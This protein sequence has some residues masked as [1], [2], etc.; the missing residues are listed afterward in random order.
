MPTSPVET[1]FLRLYKGKKS[2]QGRLKSTAYRAFFGVIDADL[3]L[4]MRF[5]PKEFHFTDDLLRIAT[6]ISHSLRKKKIA[7]RR[8][9]LIELLDR[10]ADV[11]AY[12]DL[13]S[14]V[15][16]ALSS[17][18]SGHPWCI[19]MAVS[20]PAAFWLSEFLKRRL[21]PF[22]S[23]KAIGLVL[24]GCGDEIKIEVLSRGKLPRIQKL[25]QLE[26][27]CPQ[28]EPSKLPQIHKSP[29]EIES[30][31]RILFGHFEVEV[32]GVKHH[33]PAV[34]SVKKLSGDR[35]FIQY[36]HEEIVRR[37]GKP[38]YQVLPIGIPL[39]GIENLS[40]S[41]IEGEINRLLLRDLSNLQR[42]SD[43][44]LL[45]DFISPIYSLDRLCAKLRSGSAKDL[46]I[47]GIGNYM[48]VPRVRDVR[49]QSFVQTN[50]R[51]SP[52]GP[53]C[54]F[55][56]QEVP[57]IKG[58]DYESLSRQAG[59]FDPF[60][61]WELIKESP[62][63]YRAG[64]WPSD[65]TP[66]HYQFRIMIKP[67]LKRHCH[68]LSL[69]FRHLLESLNILPGWI[70]KILCIQYEESETLA[71]GLANVVGLS[72]KDVIA[73]PRKHLASIAGADVS[74]ELWRFITETYGK[75][76]LRHQNVVIV[77]QAAHHLKTLSALRTV[78]EHLDSHILAFAVV[79]DRTDAALVL[80]DFLHDSHYIYLYSWPSPPRLPYECPCAGVTR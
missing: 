7:T 62:D 24:F 74:E 22:C 6:N 68:G 65:R 44:V 14:A 29:E 79:V 9:L 53:G 48:G 37:L 51:V 75:S 59:G 58:E 69:R 52:P 18:K 39:G 72:S 2:A 70:D 32:D 54:P 43:V 49:M 66:N 46:I 31:F 57:L 5:I 20:N 71:L 34:A 77:D 63:Y 19:A 64:H 12:D 1:I 61:F 11:Y 21:Q 76:K 25:P 13:C 56:N 23:R 26:T 27:Y 50:Y 30:D 17:E 38:D 60:T 78:C 42:G 45:C 4:R 36:L 80:G 3:A 10:D 16:S 40:V 15:Y 35:V 67:M 55:C 47:M 73:I 28:E 8:I 41:L 33:V